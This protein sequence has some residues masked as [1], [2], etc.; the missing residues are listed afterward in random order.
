MHVCE[1]RAGTN[2]EKTVCDNFNTFHGVS[3]AGVILSNFASN[4]FEDY[5]FK[6][7]L[8][9]FQNLCYI[10]WLSYTIVKTFINIRCIEM[11]FY[12]KM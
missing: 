5:D 3:K 11:Y 4:Y 1:K 10:K 9:K 12:I 2:R 6:K 7:S 8:D